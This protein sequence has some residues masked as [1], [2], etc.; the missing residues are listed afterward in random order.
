T[1]LYPD[2][3]FE[4]VSTDTRALRGGEL[5]VALRGEHYDA[6]DF[7]ADAA[8][9]AAGLVVE[10]PDKQISCPQWVVPD[11]TRALAQIAL[12]A[13]QAFTGPVIAVTG[14]SGKTSVKEMITA[15]LGRAGPTLA[16]RGNL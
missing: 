5:F 2:C 9:K 10:R 14:S 11:T 15:I 13:R 4:A 12:L 8:R 3:T 1:L 7:L 6:H 16:T